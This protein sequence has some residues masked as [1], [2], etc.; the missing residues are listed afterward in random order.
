MPLRL[1]G[2]FSKNLERNVAIRYGC[3]ALDDAYAP[4]RTPLFGSRVTLVH[5][6][7]WLFGGPGRR[8]FC[9]G[10]RCWFGFGCCCS[11]CFGWFAAIDFGRGLR[12][13]CIGR[14]RGNL[15]RRFLLFRR[16]LLLFF[17][18][19]GD[20]GCRCWCRFFHHRFF[21]GCCLGRSNL[22]F[23]CWFQNGSSGSL[24]GGYCGFCFFGWCRLCLWTGGNSPR[25]HRSRDNRRGH[26]RGHALVLLGSNGYFGG[27]L[28]FGSLGRSR[29][30]GGRS[31][32]LQR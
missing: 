1:L 18:W 3:V 30:K 28:L 27:S 32:S 25:N 8:L 29:H 6:G 2:K 21:D 10:F 4:Q 26:R 23:R 16:S 14:N 15:L 5:N 11:L 31:Q 17:L 12:Y 13:S 9:C 24:C 22:S 7:R 19:I 20:F